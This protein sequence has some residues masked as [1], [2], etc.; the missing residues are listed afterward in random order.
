MSSFGEGHIVIE[1]PE[2]LRH[3]IEDTLGELTARQLRP[4]LTEA[5]VPDPGRY[6]LALDELPLRGTVS[7]VPP[8][9][10][11]A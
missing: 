2:W 9:G 1:I 6:E 3:E 4:A 7:Q 10:A 8:P 11:E 5:G